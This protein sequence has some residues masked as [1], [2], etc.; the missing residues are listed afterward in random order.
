MKN[1]VPKVTLP[2]FDDLFKSEEI[3]QEERLERILRVPAEEIFPYARQPYSIDRPTADLA[4][5]MDSIERMGI[6]EPLITRP[7][8]D[9]GYEIVSGHRR[10]Y[11]GRMIGLPDRPIIVRDYTDDEAD[12]LVADANI[13]REDLLPSEKARAYKLKLDAMKR[14]AGRPA[15]INGDQVGLHLYQGKSKELLAEQVGESA[16]QIQRYIR[17]NHLIPELLEQVDNGALKFTAAADYISH[18]TGEEQVELAHIIE[19][20]EISPSIGQVQQLKQL[21][22]EGILTNDKM[23]D[24]LNEEKPFEIKV[25]IKQDKLKKYFPKGFTPQQMEHVI[26]GLLEDWQKKQLRQRQQNMSR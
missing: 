11:C 3:R 17:L 16:T 15:K 13:K 20:D 8:E 19:R 2:Q 21:S 7:R 4:Q 23:E 12:I 10:D 22:A 18:L 6:T 24:I 25:I 26:L 5:L 1:N 14:Q 9:G